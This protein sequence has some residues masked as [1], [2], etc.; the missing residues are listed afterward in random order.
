LNTPVGFGVTRIAT[1]HGANMTEAEYIQY[2]VPKI[3]DALN[4]ERRLRRRM[5]ASPKRRW[6]YTFV[7]LNRKKV[8]PSEFSASHRFHPVYLLPSFSF[9]WDRWLDSQAMRLGFIW[10]T[11]DFNIRFDFIRFH[12]RL[13]VATWKE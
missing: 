1:T 10:I 9:L 13:G 8:T 3:E 2:R 12:I 7:W 11:N 6:K 4:F 5:L